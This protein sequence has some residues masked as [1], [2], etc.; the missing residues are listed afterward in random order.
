LNSQFVCN[1]IDVV[2]N[3]YNAFLVMEKCD[4]TLADAIQSWRDNKVKLTEDEILRIVKQV[5]EG[6]AQLQQFDVLYGDLCPK[7][8][9]CWGQSRD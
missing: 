5:L 8:V 2:R 7:N 3:R 9:V 4:F 6:L 1:G